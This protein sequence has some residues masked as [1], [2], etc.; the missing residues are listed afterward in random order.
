MP[1]FYVYAPVTGTVV[2]CWTGPVTCAPNP[3]V[4]R[5]DRQIAATGK[6]CDQLSCGSC[7]HPSVSCSEPQDI[8]TGT[9]TPDIVFTADPI[10]ASIWVGLANNSCSAASGCSSLPYTRVMNV[11][12]YSGLNGSGKLLGAVTFAHVNNGL[13]SGYY[14]TSIEPGTGRAYKVIGSVAPG[15]CGQCYTGPHV[16]WERCGNSVV[17][18]SISCGDTMLRGLSWVFRYF[19]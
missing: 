14:N 7:C 4:C 3:V 2:S 6:Y 8:N 16:H 11:Y 12:M 13:P 1:S 5:T 10:V 15:S 19:Y 17:N 18:G 9:A